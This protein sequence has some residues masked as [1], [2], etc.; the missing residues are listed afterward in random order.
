MGESHARLLILLCALTFGCYFAAF[1]RLPVVPLYAKSLGIG[2]GQI[3]IINSAF[4][5]MAALLSLPMGLLSDRWGRKRLAGAGML[6]L[7]LTA[8]SLS[9]CRSFPSLTLAY[10][11][12]GAATA[13]FGPT[14]M[15]FVAHISPASHLGRSYGWYTTAIFCGM[16]LGPGAGGFLAGK[17]GFVPVFWIAGGVLL[18]NLLLFQWRLPPEESRAEGG[19]PALLPTLAGLLHN[20][21]LVGCWTVTMGACFGLGMFISFIPLHAQEQGLPVERIGL[22]FF[23]QGLCNALSRIP[24]GHLSDRVTDRGRLVV[25]GLLA[26]ALSMV[27][28]GASMT[29]LHFILFAIVLGGG[30]GLAFTS[31]G[32]L[33]AQSVTPGLRGV[34]MGGYN[35]CI[36]SGLMISSA[37]MGRVCEAIGFRNGFYLTAAGNL[38]LICV[39]LLSRKAA[40]PIRRHQADRNGGKGHGQDL[41]KGVEAREKKTGSGG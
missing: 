19:K 28:F 34:A 12:F 37:V 27:G 5:L 33:V 39:F 20:R 30:M 40:S 7:A 3:G 25:A 15:A 41:R 38:L 23:V 32:A 31:I 29:A 8:F 22:I 17:L 35:T 2:T 36:Y 18:L 16:S 1:M 4:F 6:L 11:M 14:M 21:T 13:A 10:L 24:F 26:F 9:L